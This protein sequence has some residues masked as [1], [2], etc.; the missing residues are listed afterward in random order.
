ML[1]TCLKNEALYNMQQYSGEHLKN[2]YHSIFVHCH[3]TPSK[4]S[5]HQLNLQFFVTMDLALRPACTFTNH[6]LLAILPTHPMIK[7]TTKNTSFPPFLFPV[8]S[9]TKRRNV[10]IFLILLL[11]SFSSDNRNVK[12]IFSFLI[13]IFGF[14]ISHSFLK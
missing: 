2:C 11:Y 6:H 7:L 3:S 5:L 8:V 4:V 1:I 14:L 9:L 12:I 10:N 13:S